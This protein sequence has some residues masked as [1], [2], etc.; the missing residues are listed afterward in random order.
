MNEDEKKQKELQ[1]LVENRNLIETSLL[2]KVKKWG[3]L[4]IGYL[5]WINGELT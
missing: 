2:Q 5:K 3:D 4:K 1:L